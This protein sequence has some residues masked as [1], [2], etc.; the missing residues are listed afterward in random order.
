MIAS[1]SQTFQSSCPL[2]VRT[3][4][5]STF[6]QSIGK[7]QYVSTS[8]NCIK[9][10]LKYLGYKCCDLVRVKSCRQR[11]FMST[12]D[13]PITLG[14]V[15]SVTMMETYGKQNNKIL[16]NVMNTV[17]VIS[18]KQCGWSATIP[19]CMRF[20]QKR[21]GGWLRWVDWE[22]LRLIAISASSNN[23]RLVFC[24]VHTSVCQLSCPTCELT[25]HWNVIGLF[26]ILH[27]NLWVQGAAAVSVHNCRVN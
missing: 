11:L 15:V 8:S 7:G 13:S 26:K 23:S 19:L 9:V 25:K 22:L 2:F 10:N 18:Y 27:W 3:I 6:P 16:N 14:K 12:A 4:F 5:W 21:E 17:K 24:K 1:S 20:S